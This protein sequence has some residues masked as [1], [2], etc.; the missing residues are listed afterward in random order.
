MKS[1]IVSNEDQIRR[2][3]NDWAKAVRARDMGFCARDDRRGDHQTLG[4]KDRVTND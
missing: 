1:N 3:V 2:L 4:K